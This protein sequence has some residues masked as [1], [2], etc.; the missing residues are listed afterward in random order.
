MANHKKTETAAKLKKFYS[1]M[2]EAFRLTEI[3]NGMRFFEMNTRCEATD[4]TYEEEK[5]LL[6]SIGFLNKISYLKTE[7]LAD[8]I[9]YYNEVNSYS[10]GD[11]KF[12]VY[13]NDGSIFWITPSADTVHYDVNGEKGPNKLCRDIFEFYLYTEGICSSQNDC[14]GYNSSAYDQTIPTFN[15]YV[16]NIWDYES[17]GEIQGCTRILENAGWEFNDDYPYKL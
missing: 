13:L 17:N 6:E 8:N 15:T 1:T 9:N 10:Y 2:S 14:Y 7:N 3:E 12:A 5:E 16:R 4:C 11:N